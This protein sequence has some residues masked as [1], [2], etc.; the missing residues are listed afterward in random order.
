MLKGVFAVAATAAACSV[1]FAA[2]LLAANLAA[3]VSK[4]NRTV[5]V[6]DGEVAEGDASHLK[7]IIRSS[8]DAGHPVSGMR[9]NSSGGSLLES[10][11]LAGLIQNAKIPTVVANGATCASACFIAFA[12]GSQ[13]FVSANA[14]VAIPGA[15][16]GYSRDAGGGASSIAR[17]VREIGVPDV[18]IEKMLAT[19]IDEIA[20]LTPDD[21]RAMGV[22]ITGASGQA[23]P[24][25]PVAAQSPAQ[26][27]SRPASA[28]TRP[29]GV[30]TTR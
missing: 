16:D 11:R 8:I 12:A 22:K 3:T 15:A 10:V 26:R 5:V 9:F 21:L 24:D 20:W 18:I 17:V 27:A 23:A 7:H 13:K 4:E 25:Q 14:S 28:P 30:L 19:R 1:A 29:P 6:L 2:D